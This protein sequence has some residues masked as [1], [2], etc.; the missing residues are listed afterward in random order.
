MDMV[1]EDVLVFDQWRINMIR[2]S[3]EGLPA[4]AVVNIP[5]NYDIMVDAVQDAM[6][7]MSF[8]LRR[9]FELT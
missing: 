8:S 2:Y 9:E 3:R 7:M 4:R 1:V 6:P 5:L